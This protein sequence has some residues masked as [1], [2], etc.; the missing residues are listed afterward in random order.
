M[1]KLIHISENNFTKYY[2]PETD[3]N[4]IRLTAPA[5]NLLPYERYCKYASPINF[6]GA[7][8]NEY[9]SYHFDFSNGLTNTAGRRL[10]QIN[11]I[12]NIVD[13]KPGRY[14]VCLR[15]KNIKGTYNLGNAGCWGNYYTISTGAIGS[16][17]FGQIIITPGNADYIYN[18]VFDISDNQLLYTLC[19]GSD[20]LSYSTAQRDLSFDVEFI[21]LFNGEISIE[22]PSNTISERPR[23]TISNSDSIIGEYKISTNIMRHLNQIERHI[24]SKN[25]VFHIGFR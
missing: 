13:F 15:V 25:D 10:L 16:I 3:V 14:T 18:F 19:F 12:Q 1:N 20:I 5:I 22:R 6:D 23:I 17:T 4:S 24:V 9:G 7:F 11:N 2:T 8:V 21:G